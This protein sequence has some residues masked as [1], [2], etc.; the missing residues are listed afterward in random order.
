[1]YS[2]DNLSD[3]NRWWRAKGGRPVLFLPRFIDCSS[4]DGQ[5]LVLVHLLR[6]WI[7]LEELRTA[8]SCRYPLSRRFCA[9]LGSSKDLFL[10]RGQLRH[11][12]HSGL[13]KLVALRCC[14]YMRIY[15]NSFPFVFP[16]LAM[17]SS[18]AAALISADFFL[19]AVEE[20]F[21]WPLSKSVT[22]HALSYFFRSGNFT[23]TFGDHMSKWVS[24]ETN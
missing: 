18:T 2:K 6:P 15:K 9:A 17:S 16:G 8:R 10:P 20:Y 11:E 23:S 19:D 1:M 22:G 12:F 3:I 21:K 7:W 24:R 14:I 4:G 5:N 13:S